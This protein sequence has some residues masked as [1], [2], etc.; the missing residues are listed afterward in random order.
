MML[1]ENN[2]LKFAAQS[3]RNPRC[4]SINEFMEDL[5][6][7]KY[8]KRLLNRYVRTGDL[9]ERLILNHIISIYNVFDIA[10]ANEILFYRC[11]KESWC[12]LKSFLVF[13]NYVPEEFLKEYKAD[14]VVLSRL[15]SI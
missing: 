10:S 11:E 7:V 13:L 8:I 14:K 9:Q 5:S 3:Y 12:A 2:F 15:Q 6:R 1:N 4:L